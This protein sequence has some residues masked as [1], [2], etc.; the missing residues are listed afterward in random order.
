MR[1][2]H[3]YI[4]C[5]LLLLRAALTTACGDQVGQ[6]TLR[7]LDVSRERPL[8]TEVW[9]PTSDRPTAGDQQAPSPFVRSPTVRDGKLPAGKHAAILMSHG[10]GG[11]RMTM[12]WLAFAL[13]E[14]G[15]VVIAVDH[16]GNT[17]DTAQVEY[18]VRAWERPQDLTYV[19]NELLRDPTYSAIIDPDRI[20]AAGFSLGGYTV[21]ALAGA[22]MDIDALY[23]FTET[24]DG[25]REANVP[26]LPGLAEY[27]QQPS[28]RERLSA[29]FKKAP[30]LRDTRVKAVVAL[31][32]AIG[33]AFADAKQC[34]D[35]TAPTLII[36]GQADAAAPVPTNARHYHEL[37]PQSRLVILPGEV[38]HYVF[39]N[40]ALEGL[41]E[42]LPAL[43]KDPP[44]VSRA[45][46]HRTVSALTLKFFGEHL[47]PSP[48]AHP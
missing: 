35:V 22:A 46:I 27:M 4:L 18:F 19:L 12:E 13:A 21:L 40:E 16:W 1:S 5:S 26:E 15:Y 36:A 30:P 38:G 31:T 20:G 29:L 17:Y 43:F 6:R 9:Y 11:S 42:Q 34:A 2:S 10:T 23:R 8:V 39:L 37:I 33:Q 41:R 25:K 44:S 48:G 28:N 32:P 7:F 24:E 3:P 14:A 47:A 45:E